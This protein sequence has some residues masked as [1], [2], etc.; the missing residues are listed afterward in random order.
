MLVIDVGLREMFPADRLVECTTLGLGLGTGA[1]EKLG[2][3]CALGVGVPCIGGGSVVADGKGVADG[4]VVA[5]ALGGEGNTT[6]RRSATLIRCCRF[7]NK[8]ISKLLRVSPSP[9]L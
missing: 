6:P 5:G 4:R 8:W 9:G 3:T 2:V 1:A 7:F